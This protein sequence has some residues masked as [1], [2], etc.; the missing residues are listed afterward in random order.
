VHVFLDFRVAI[1]K[2]GEIVEASFMMMNKVY[3]SCFDNDKDDDKK[4]KE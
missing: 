1:I 3:S 4:P 2:N